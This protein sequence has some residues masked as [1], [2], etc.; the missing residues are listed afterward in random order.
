[1][2]SMSSK[3]LARNLM[4]KASILESI[5]SPKPLSIRPAGHQIPNRFFIAMSYTNSHLRP[6]GESGFRIRVCMTAKA[7]IQARLGN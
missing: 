1:M 7:S 4:G 3:Q 5:N 2:G 6:S